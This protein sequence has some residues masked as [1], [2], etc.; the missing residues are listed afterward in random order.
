MAADG[1]DQS[2]LLGYNTGSYDG[3]M[4]LV[5]V[6]VAVAGIAGVME[7]STYLGIC[8]LAL[9]VPLAHQANS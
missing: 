4:D 9:W 1:S 8:V 2:G 3:P 6:V 5:M 7:Y